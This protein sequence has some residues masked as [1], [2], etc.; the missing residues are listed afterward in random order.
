MINCSD[1]LRIFKVLCTIVLIATNNAGLFTIQLENIV[2]SI[3][4]EFIISSIFV[5]ITE[6]LYVS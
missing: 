1:L 2:I 6:V 4:Y 3:K 5:H